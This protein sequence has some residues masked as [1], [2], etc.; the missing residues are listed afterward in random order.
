[1]KPRILICDTYYDAAIQ[2]LPFNPASTYESNLQD[3]LYQSFG[4]S[5]FYS[6]NLNALGWEATDII[7]NHDRLQNLWSAQYGENGGGSYWSL[8]DQ[9]NFYKPDVIF[10]QNLGLPITGSMGVP[11]V[12][13]L[14]C[15]WPGDQHVSKCQIIFTSFPHYVARIEALGVK[16]IYSPLA[17]DPI[18]LERCAPLPT[19]RI[20]DVTFVGGVSNPGHWRRGMEVLNAVAEAIP[21]FK[22]WGYGAECLPI[23][24]ALFQAYQGEA[25]GLD[26]YR[27]FLQSKI[28]LNRHGE[29]A[30]GYSNNMRMF[31]ATGCGALL[32]TEV[33][34]NLDSLFYPGEKIGYSGIEQLISSIK[35]LLDNPHSI[36]AIAKRGQERTLRDHTY[37]KRMKTV[38]DTFQ[39]CLSLQTT[40]K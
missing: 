11:I 25:W 31:E 18:V 17:F 26:M 16:A 22:W 10:L 21:S 13:Q 19:D 6:R 27:I 38:S 33:S 15:P 39:Q 7:V 34:E 1:M 29:V 35:V 23:S 36:D 40:A 5:D 28:V 4:T 30:E 12:G 20:Y 2:S 37:A 3:I 8:N 32:A 24:S 14:S 9:V